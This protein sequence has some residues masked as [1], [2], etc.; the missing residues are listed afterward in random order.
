MSPEAAPPRRDAD[1]DDGLSR[2][3][4][5]SV[6][7]VMNLI[8]RKAPITRRALEGI[9]GFSHPTVIRD[10]V[11]L[12]Q[13]GLVS[14]SPLRDPGRRGKTAANL[15]VK[16][17]GKYLIAVEV[18]SNLLIGVLMDFA[19]TVF[20][21]ASAVCRSRK[22]DDTVARIVETVQSLRLRA[23]RRGRILGLCVAF[24]GTI[25]SDPKMVRSFHG[26]GGWEDYPLAHVLEARFG[27]E[28][29]L[30]HNSNAHIRAEYHF[31]SGASERNMLGVY[32]DNGMGM[33]ILVDGS[34]YEGTTF[35]AGEIGHL[36]YGD[37]DEPCHCGRRGC[38][39]RF[40]S[41][42][43]LLE[44]MNARLGTRYSTI[45][46]LLAKA[47]LSTDDRSFVSA[48]LEQALLV[49]SRGIATAVTLFNP[50]RVV[51]HGGI[52]P[53]APENIDRLRAY[54]TTH[55]FPASAG[56][57][58]ALST[59]DDTAAALGAGATFVERFYDVRRG[60]ISSVL[61]IRP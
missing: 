36:P 10:V 43:Y 17:D 41:E 7:K 31:A 13:A 24:P 14:E 9:S 42:V 19:G 61:K 3:H 27:I 55:A 44:K 12:V 32:L 46:D 53:L 23:R 8:Y 28:T 6:L 20:H 54:V 48:L 15:Q 59:L 25:G 34:V 49:L 57:T 38:L 37:A 40:G 60:Y 58:I 18:R 52:V 56:V 51:V 21:R 4:T 2:K 47:A 16:R 33:G 11:R 50:G 22:R 26:R 30:V 1:L 45:R 35:A 39:E 5:A 29:L